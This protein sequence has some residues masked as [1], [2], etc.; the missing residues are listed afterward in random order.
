MP[1]FALSLPLPPSPLLLRKYDI[2]SI[3]DA[4]CGGMV[5]MPLVLQQ[6]PEVTYT[7]LD[8]TCH[9]VRQHKVTFKD[10]ARWRFFC[11][12]VCAQPLVKADLVFSRDALQHLTL[13]HTFK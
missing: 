12:D 1:L 4:P 2:K 10:Q 9:I 13:N 6:L 5:W 7:G 3:L 8:V 11:S